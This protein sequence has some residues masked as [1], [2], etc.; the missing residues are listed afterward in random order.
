MFVEL[1]D[2]STVSSVSG[3][4]VG[5]ALVV[6]TPI[7]STAVDV[8]FGFD[9]LGIGLWLLE[10]SL[11]R[12][13]RSASRMFNLT[14]QRASCYENVY[15]VDK[16]TKMGAP[17]SVQWRL[18]DLEILWWSKHETCLH[19]IQLEW[20]VRYGRL[21]SRRYRTHGSVG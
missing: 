10:S 13:L 8:V 1:A 11:R 7:S 9:V 21:V 15:R 3:L 12:R 17:S 16:A 4:L 6:S 18:V 14:P 20:H 5:E 19:N 2:C